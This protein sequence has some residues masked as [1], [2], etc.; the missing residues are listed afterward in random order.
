M[1]RRSPATASRPGLKIAV[2]GTPVHFFGLVLLAAAVG[3]FLSNSAVVSATESGAGDLA[4]L[5]RMARAKQLGQAPKWRRLL[6][7]RDRMFGP[8][9]SV[10]P[11]G[12]GFFAAPSG[13][14]DPEAELEATLTAMALPLSATGGDPDQHPQ[15]RWPARRQF[16]F[17]NLDAQGKSIPLVDCPGLRR[18]RSWVTGERLT[19]VFSAAYGGNP[20]SMFG[21]TFL[22]LK[23]Q[24]WSRRGD[25]PLLSP[26]INFA[27]VGDFSN[28]D[29]ISF[30]VKGLAGGFPGS[31]HVGRYFERVQEYGN[32]ESRDLWE[33]DLTLSPEVVDHLLL[34]LWEIGNQR[35]GYYYLDE[36]CSLLVLMLL[37][38]ADER[39]DLVSGVGLVVAPQD[40]LRAVT[41]QP[42]VVAG[43][44]FR[45]SA[46]RRFETVLARLTQPEQ[47]ALAALL[48]T[49][50]GIAGSM[51]LLDWARE[52]RSQAPTAREAL[53]IDAALENITAV[54]RLAAQRQPERYRERYAQLLRRRSQLA[55]PPIQ[56]FP[57]VNPPP[58]AGHGSGRLGGGVYGAT[59]PAS[60]LQ[61]GVG[62]GALVT[63]RLKLH[64]VASPS[65]GYHPWLGIGFLEGTVTHRFDTNSSRLTNLTIID[66]LSLTP[67]QAF[68]RQPSWALKVGFADELSL[69]GGRQRRLSAEGGFGG[70]WATSGGEAALFFLANAR[71]SLGGEGGGR[72]GPGIRLGWLLRG[73]R[74]FSLTG[75]AHTSCEIE[76]G[77]RLEQSDLSAT[78]T[79]ALPEKSELRLTVERR[80]A[81]LPAATGFGSS[82]Q[83]VL[84]HYL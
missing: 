77:Q 59:G 81:R 67:L 46:R 24:A 73:S 64:D 43:V 22:Q 36:N 39:L 76:G 48:E 44:R 60:S 14:V 11:A 55:A 47:E 15:C 13:P 71:L 38:A 40:A 70:T 82:G 53:V 56:D 61:P 32:W 27:A 30:V 16:L 34:S 54:E 68:D 69:I 79:A 49:K 37:E 10:V 21:H 45:A 4:A 6:Y 1:L 74:G 84:L 83:L 5:Q 28:S 66:V 8:D 80:A 65:A 51:D 12:G 50:D 35:L 9:R 72:F 75:S 62:P 17:A 33:Y 7:Y 2:A 42:G 78:M 20:V 31:F 41:R 57:P 18:W 52:L 19:L 58:D 3:G 63:A 23:P 25:S 29:P 26:V